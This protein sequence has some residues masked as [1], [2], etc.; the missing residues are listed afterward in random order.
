M[1]DKSTKADSPL[2]PIFRLLPAL[3]LV[4]DP[5]LR[6]IDATDAYVANTASNRDL[7]VG[8]HILS[9]FPEDSNPSH[10]EAKR[11]LEESLQHVLQFL[12]PHTMP[13]FRYDIPT[14]SGNDYEERFWETINRPIL[15]G[16]GNLQYILLETRDVTKQQLQV[17]ENH[18]NTARL[19]LL[20]VALDAITW[21]YDAIN[22]KVNWS[23][24]LQSAFGY[25]TDQLPLGKST[26]V[27]LIHPE[28]LPLTQQSINQAR[29][30]YEKVWTG[31][32]RFRK[33]DGTYADVMDQRYLI[34]NKNGNVRRMI[35]SLI[36]VSKTKQTELEAKENN[37]RFHHLLEVLPFMAWTAA[38]NGQI[39]HFNQAWHSFT[40]M[41]QGQTDRWVSYVHPE[42]TAKVLTSWHESIRRGSPYEV[43]YRV[44][45][46]LENTYYWFMER[47][48]PLY[49]D[50]GKVKLW[51]GTFTDI[52]EQKTVL[53]KL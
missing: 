46:K 38:P 19:N 40:G 34:Y 9:S 8:K 45:N 15:D 26:W 48:L 31:K 52:H 32:Y 17:Q 27:E 47:G 10:E 4:M 28:D 14:P 33:A 13:L 6:I 12:E 24:E 51:I 3:Y 1:V 22:D 53:E 36:D 30:A 50:T 42:D 18:F 23:S 35:G 44:L 29:S 21:E 16:N 7:F 37:T 49:D 20:A 39:L 11:N 43:E 2:G 5:E 41:P 25:T